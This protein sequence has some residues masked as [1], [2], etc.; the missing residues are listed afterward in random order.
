MAVLSNE[1]MLCQFQAQPWSLGGLGYVEGPEDYMKREK[2]PAEPALHSISPIC[3]D[4]GEAI[5]DLPGET[6][7]QLKTNE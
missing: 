5:L 1:V 4:V 7:H 3:Q 2:R 6:G